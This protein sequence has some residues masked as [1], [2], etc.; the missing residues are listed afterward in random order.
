M[1]TRGVGTEK[2]ELHEGDELVRLL[3]AAAGMTRFEAE[4]AFALSLVRHGRLH[5]VDPDFL[6]FTRREELE[7]PEPIRE[8]RLWA[9]H[10]GAPRA[11]ARA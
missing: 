1:R 3:E 9:P 7:E 8:P 11:R 4:N 5:A 2:G 6:E 10:L